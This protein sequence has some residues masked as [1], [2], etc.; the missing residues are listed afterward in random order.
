LYSENEVNALRLMEAEEL[1]LFDFAAEEDREAWSL[2]MA[3]RRHRASIAYLF[4]RFSFTTSIG[5]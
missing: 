5:L 3:L 4:R 1:S 2:A